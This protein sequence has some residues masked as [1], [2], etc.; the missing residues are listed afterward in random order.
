M[1]KRIMF[2]ALGLAL[3]AAPLISS[4]QTTCSP[5]PVQCP[6]GQTQ[7]YAAAGT[8]C[9]NG[10]YTSVVGTLLA[11]AAT[12]PT[13]AVI[14][15]TPTTAAP[16]PASTLRT[17]P[18]PNI[19]MLGSSGATVTTIQQQL[20]TLG[21]LNQSNVTG[22][23]GP[24]T[25]TALQA[26]QASQG[27]ASSG[28][29]TSTGYG[30]VGPKTRAA[31]AMAVQDAGTSSTA[32]SAS[33][34]TPANI[35]APSYTGS[36]VPIIQGS[37]ASPGV[38][39]A[40]AS[41]TGT[42]SLIQTLLA[43]IAALQAQVAKLT[44]ISSQVKTPAAVVQ[45]PAPVQ[46][47]TV[48]TATTVTPVSCT[49]NGQS[50]TSGASVIAYQ[51]SSVP[52]GQT[53]QS[54]TRTCGNGTFSGSYTSVS[55][56]II[57]ATTQ[58]APQACTWN[59]QSVTSGSSVTAYQ[60]SSV[61]FGQTCVSETRGCQNGALS[62]SY[63]NSSC[64]I[65]SPQPCTFNGSSV[66]D[67]SSVTAY[68]A[69]SVAAGSSCVSEQRTCSNGTLSGSYTN[70]VCAVAAAPAPASCTFNGST[71]ASGSNVTAYQSSSVAAGSQCVSETRTC[72]NGI[73]SGSLTNAACSVA[74]ATPAATAGSQNF[75]TPGT[76]TFTIPA[77]GTLTVV[78]KGA[79]GGASHIFGWAGGQAGGGSSFTVA[80]Q[81]PVV[82]NGG[83]IGAVN[84]PG[85]CDQGSPGTASGGD[86]NTT[87]GG[88]VGLSWSVC[89]GSSIIGGSGGL[90]QKTYT[91]G[92]LQVGTQV[93]I[94]VG[95]NGSVPSPFV[96]TPGQ[97]G[98]V[99][100]TWTGTQASAADKNENLANALTALQSA[101]QALISKL[102]Q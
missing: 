21:Y 85:A 95:A 54:Q 25:K 81:T 4:A 94:T 40:S 66:A 33:S 50:L 35:P 90:A 14:Q 45:T 52:A 91:S 30:L 70:A 58:T 100:I 75:M 10:G 17:N 2:A 96:G 36:I 84:G 31:L 9:A 76:Y 77:Y 60:S 12:P 64:T 82:A 69:S 43:Q 88:A 97:D 47:P 19:F 48:T 62:G 42:S 102:G 39:S 65:A 87:G 67:S 23:F 99:S 68:Q 20:A 92:Q 29:E 15:T 44:M 34:P 79:G 13:Q 80:N 78:V 1:P 37:S 8:T 98:S 41:D 6:D 101:L 86:V 61:A 49:W 46:S 38:N 72:T 93:T 57:P 26:F 18:N 16:T 56:Y 59:G 24:L 3:I 51:S 74:A 32:P 83:G 5:T 89:N 28:N 73:L 55:C 27:I 71:V 63:A 53:C 11:P 7:F 22:Y